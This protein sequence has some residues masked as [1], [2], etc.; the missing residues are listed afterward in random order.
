MSYACRDVTQLDGQ[1]ANIFI[2][3]SFIGMSFSINHVVKTC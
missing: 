3:I 1:E 2:F